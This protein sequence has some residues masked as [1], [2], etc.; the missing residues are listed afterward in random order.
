MKRLL[1]FAAGALLAAT[2]F[3]GPAAA[4]DLRGRLALTAKL[5]VVNPRDSE[6][7]KGG[8]RV[9]VSTDAG[10]IVGGGLLYGVDDNVAF[11]LELVRSSCD[12]AAWG[13]AQVKDL[14]FGAQYRFPER[15]RLVPYL[16]AGVDVLIN[17]LERSASSAD[18]V[19]GVHL[20]GGIDYLLTRQVALTAELRG[21]EAFSADVKGLDGSRVGSFDPSNISFM[22]GGRFFFN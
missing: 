6:I 2:F 7:T 8:D 3:A 22:V 15:S 20:A 4:D 19:L 17:D 11:E 21:V 9:V 10:F 16:G 14:S 13:D 12:T 1:A 5:G 18:T